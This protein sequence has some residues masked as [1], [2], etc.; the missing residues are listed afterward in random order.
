M[1]DHYITIARD[2]Q[3]E[4]DIKK[5]RFICAL[6][7]IETEEEAKDLIQAAKKEHP[8][9][10]HHC[11]AFILGKQGE[12]RRSSDDGEPSGTAG[13]PILEVLTQNQVVNVLAIVIRYF[14]GIKLGAGGLI[15][16][17]ST[18]TSHALQD[19]GLVDVRQERQLFVT[20]DY[21]Q[22]DKLTHYLQTIDQ[23]I[24]KID[25]AE[26]VQMTLCTSLEDQFVSAITDFV[27][28]QVQI[29]R[30]EIVEVCYPYTPN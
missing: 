14:G 21:A 15:R 19:V 9:A 18:S 26:T 6:Y 30:G 7:H 2:H 22:V 13:A 17:Y 27:N 3:A 16:A 4:I 5:S 20:I 11:S 28:G 23:P 24:Q 1:L 10:N 29:K 8:K 25:Y 12:I